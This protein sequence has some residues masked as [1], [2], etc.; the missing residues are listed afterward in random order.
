M[1]TSE[2]QSFVYDELQRLTNGQGAYGNLEFAYDSVG[3]RTSKTIDA[4]PETYLYI[5]NQLTSV[6][7]TT[8]AYDAA[9]NL[10][11]KGTDTFAYNKANRLST[12]TVAGIGYHYRY[13][14]NG[15]RVVKDTNGQVRFY[16]YDANGL[17]LAETDQHGNSLVCLLYTSPSPRDLST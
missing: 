14:H 12:A 16:H 6:G 17:L 8:L 4:V 13:D 1:Q 7:G 11:S 10:I 3:N 2:N 9:G 5:D 15:Q